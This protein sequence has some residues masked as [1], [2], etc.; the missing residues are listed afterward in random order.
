MNFKQGNHNTFSYSTPL[1]ELH[2]LISNAN[3]VY[4]NTSNVMFSD[5]VYDDILDIYNSRSNTKY[6]DIGSVPEGT[7]SDKV[8]LPYHMGSMNK[9]YSITE[10]NTWT[11]KNACDSYIITPK[12]DGTSCLI[13]ITSTTVDIYSRGNGM[14]GKTMTHLQPYIL[15]PTHLNKVRDYLKKHKQSKFVCRGELII[16]KTTFSNFSGQFKSARS[17]INGLSNQKASKETTTLNSVEFMLF[18]V[19]EPSYKPEEQF[20]LAESLGF[21]TVEPFKITFSK[22]NDANVTIENSLLLKLLKELRASY[23]YDIDGI[24]IT[25]NIVNPICES[26]N[27]EYSIAFKSNGEGEITTVVNI[28]WNISKH[29]TLIPTI[30]FNS[31]KLGSSIVTRCTG[32]NGAYIFNNSLGKGAIIRVVLSG[33]VIPYISKVIEQALMPQMPNIKYKWNET[34]VNCEIMDECEELNIK[35]IVNFIKNIGI[36]NIS[37]GMVRHLYNHNFTSLR[38]I[39]TITHS[40]LLILPRIEEKMAIK[41][42]NSINIIVS[43]PI[44]LSKIMDGCLCFGNGFGEKRC[45]QL[46]FN[47]PDFL[48]SLPTTEELYSLPGWSS[49]SVDKLNEGIPKFKEFL[50][51]ND[52]LI[53]AD[54]HQDDYDEHIK[55]LEIKKVCIT[56]KRDLDILKFVKENHLELV[57]SITN[58]TDILVCYDKHVTS[59][60][61]DAAIKKKIPIL[62]VVEFKTKYKI[63]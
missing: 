61:V 47:Y 57:S 21:R 18:D 46:I 15:S 7:T 22:L 30:V 59:G 17:M 3:Q 24:I 63:E 31:I 35:K 25:K 60:K 56:G 32:F 55:S 33:E 49:K 37:I 10:F 52:Y 38:E 27:P 40:Q 1:D 50:E 23:N 4:Y 16:N 8:K 53:I 26:G 42:V 62:S 34:R 43:K 54:T 39:L 44:E 58:D 19:L 14:V 13:S 20:K 11:K 6:K 29:G 45:A 12:I 36:D 51:E 41:I 48:E 5:D 2:S 9:T 28:E